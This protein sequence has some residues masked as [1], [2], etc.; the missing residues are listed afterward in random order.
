[1]NQDNLD[2]PLMDFKN[3]DIRDLL[4]NYE[5]EYFSIFES[6]DIDCNYYDL[7]D[8]VNTFK[9]SN[10]IKLVSFNINSLAAKFT[11]LLDLLDFFV[12]NDIF[13]DV[14][15]LQE[16]WA[17]RDESVFNIRGYNLVY[18]DRKD[19][20]G[21]GV[22]FY[23]RNNYKFKII[24][25]LSIFIPKVFESLVIEINCKGKSISIANIYRSPTCPNNISPSE[26]NELFMNHLSNYQHYMSNV[27][28]ESF[29]LGDF[30]I[31]L[32]KKENL[33]TNFLE[34]FLTF[35]FLPCV[36]KATR[37]D[38]WA[39]SFSSI[40]NIFKNGTNKEKIVSGILDYDMSDHFPVFHIVKANVKK[41][42]KKFSQSRVINEE[43]ISNFIDFLN[44]EDW[45]PLVLEQNCPQVAFNNFLYKLSTAFNVCFP[46]R[47]RRI[48]KKIDKIEPFMTKALLKSRLR[49]LHLLALK[50]RNPTNENIV[51]YNTYR[52]LYNRLIKE[53]KI[54]H[55]N[56]ALYDNKNDMKKTWDV[57][58][59]AISKQKKT[60]EN[61]TELSFD[62]ETV[63]DN[64]QMANKLNNFFVSMADDIVKNINPPLQGDHTIHMPNIESSFIFNHITPLTLKDIVSEMENK[65]S[66]DLF[67]MSNSLIKKIINV[68]AEPLC[69][70]FNRSLTTGYIP[71][72]LKD[73]KVVPIYKLNQKSGT[74]KKLPANY[75][76]ISLL[77]IISKLLE[78]VVGKQLLD[79]LAA[80]KIIHK[81]QYG[82]QPNKSTIH[83]MVHLL[84]EIGSAKKD[85][86]VSIGIFM[87]ISRAFDCISTPIMLKKLEKIGIKNRALEW[88]KNYLSGR[89]QCTIINDIKSGFLETKRGVPQGGIISPILFLIYIN[90]LP[91]ATEMLTLLFADDSNFLIH[92]KSLEEIIPKV[93]LEMKKIC[94]WFR[95]NE[96]SIHPEK[97]KFM[98]F[99][100]KESSIK[101]ED[102]TINLNFNNEGNNDKNLIKK[103][104]Y[105][106]S[107]S[108]VPAVK[109]L[110]IYLDSKLNFEYHIKYIQKKIST[111]LFV[112][113]RVKKLL[114]E[115]SLK[116]LYTSLIHSHLEYGIIIWTSC[117]NVSYLQPLIKIQKK[118]IRII[119]NSPFNAHTAKLF[120]KYKI[121]PL[122]ELAMYNKIIFIYDF[123]TNKL[124]DSFQGMWKKN[125]EIYQN[126]RS[127]RID[128]GD[129]FYIPFNN[130]KSIEKFPLYYYQK[131]WNDICDNALLNTQLRKNRFKTTLKT[132]LFI[133]VTTTCSKPNC[134]ECN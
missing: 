128:N 23:I 125:N 74:Y 98:I 56:S 127:Q 68:V 82:F 83:P 38:K 122:N 53:A 31:D 97:T 112:I 39:N 33:S 15:A 40:D 62:G 67:E 119:S 92:G 65:V 35:G 101:W 113:N 126:R 9:N 29:I 44:T 81:H 28:C 45:Q 37:V 54:L 72:Q 16:V 104:G 30:N 87:D 120:K 89:R 50:N 42:K 55:F 78:K 3:K 63:T 22:C 20:K 99:N 124:P 85:K 95:L 121:L 6:I 46:K 118:A 77:P 100:K 102:I 79:F 69:H 52:D 94:D 76:P 60:S 86:K 130:I 110:G 115:K 66:S 105:I 114:N 27:N 26:K 108:D 71:V 111:S 109:F 73:A 47:K 41:D 116:T 4:D 59:E 106:N 5:N 51:T 64:L 21:G 19:M 84:N 129:K 90:D 93:N 36:T 96:L 24:D 88:F 49:K 43:N 61:I 1:M 103:L 91:L 123:L 7:Q 13:L 131:L 10:E 133:D 18:K 134:S 2:L 75:R 11:K 12:R 25:D 57:L 58:R 117:S 107:E 8:F 14:I 80:N 132:F 70:I 17:I 34:S 32:L 48:N